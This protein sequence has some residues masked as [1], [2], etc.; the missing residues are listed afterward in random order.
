MAEKVKCYNSMNYLLLMLTVLFFLSG[1]ISMPSGPYMPNAV[2]IIPGS[3]E[4]PF[5]GTVWDYKIMGPEI[6][7]T[8]YLHF[9]NDGTVSCSGSFSFKYTLCS[10]DAGYKVEIKKVIG[11]EDSFWTEATLTWLVIDNAEATQGIVSIKKL[12][13]IYYL[14][15]ST[16]NRIFT[17]FHFLQ[18]KDNLCFSKLQKTI[19][20]TQ[21]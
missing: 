16:V 10:G 8:Y 6:E 18:Q 19:I 12:F 3:K 21:N 11:K 20:L 7:E 4:E 5:A 9:F 1:C 13:L 2:D 14:L 17:H 15:I